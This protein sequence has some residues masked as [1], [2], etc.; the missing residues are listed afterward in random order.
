VLFA[1][2]NKNARSLGN[3]TLFLKAFNVGRLL[4]MRMRQRG[5]TVD[6]SVGIAVFR[7]GAGVIGNNCLLD[8]KVSR[9][10]QK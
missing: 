5:A 3:A 10:S 8:L 7:G 1:S 2:F 6:D 9:S 4:A